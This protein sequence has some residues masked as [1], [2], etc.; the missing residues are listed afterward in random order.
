MVRRFVPYRNVV[1]GGY[2]VNVSSAVRS[3]V[4]VSAA[5]VIFAGCSSTGSVPPLGSDSTAQA[6]HGSA[7]KN[8]LVAGVP[9]PATVRPDRRPSWISR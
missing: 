4:S 6:I 1:F 3:A 7:V 9:I 5:V 2:Y 8:V